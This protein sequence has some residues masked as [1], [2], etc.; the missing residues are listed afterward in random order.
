MQCDRQYSIERRYIPRRFCLKVKRNSRLPAGIQ[1][2]EVRRS[3][4]CLNDKIRSSWERTDVHGYMR[5]QALTRSYAE[6]YIPLQYATGI[7][8]STRY[9]CSTDRQKG[10][11]CKVSAFKPI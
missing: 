9:A 4:S 1:E 11:S 3:S 8:S 7:E 2:K 6:R 10:C 5:G